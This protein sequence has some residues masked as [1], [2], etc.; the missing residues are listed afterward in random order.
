MG[1]RRETQLP[2]LIR[3]TNNGSR[4]FNRL[5]RR[6]LFRPRFDLPQKA[7]TASGIIF[8]GSLCG[9]LP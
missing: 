9:A 6:T 8:C 4:R 7:G 2:I 1:G 3:A 5:N